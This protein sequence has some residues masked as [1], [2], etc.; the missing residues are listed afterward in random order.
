MALHGSI[1]INGHP[2]ISWRATRIENLQDEDSEYDYEYEYI[3]YYTSFPGVEKHRINGVVSHVYS[4][5]AAS[6]ASKVL[7]DAAKKRSP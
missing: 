3:E 2:F 5:G 7:A 4:E 6:L 1:L